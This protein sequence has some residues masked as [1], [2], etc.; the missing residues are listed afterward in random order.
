MTLRQPLVQEQKDK[1][2]KGRRSPQDLSRDPRVIRSLGFTQYTVKFSVI[3]I[4]SSSQ[5][6]QKVPLQ[7]AES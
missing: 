3:V 5:H 2:R 6:K 7:G 1:L 4:H